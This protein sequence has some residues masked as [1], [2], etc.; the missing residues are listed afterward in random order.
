MSGA[1]NGW[2][3]VTNAGI[4]VYDRYVPPGNPSNVDPPQT[5]WNNPVATGPQHIPQAPYPISRI[6]IKLPWG[7]PSR[8]IA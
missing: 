6:P 4:S 3:G 7:A 2:P 5:P 8:G 1:I